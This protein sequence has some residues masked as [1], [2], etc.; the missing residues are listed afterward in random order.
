M[1][2]Y[3]F[4]SIVVAKERY[5]YSH[6]LTIGT[7]SNGRSKRLANAYIHPCK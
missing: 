7:E 6:T 5:M 4:L 2:F 3:F 1:D